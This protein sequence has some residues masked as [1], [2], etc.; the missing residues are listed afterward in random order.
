[1]SHS[2]PH[3]RDPLGLPLG[4]EPGEVPVTALVLAQGHDAV[5][6]R[7]QGQ[8][9]R[10]HPRRVDTVSDTIALRLRPGSPAALL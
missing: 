4:H 6:L 1:M 7:P 8:L 5:A 2:G 9:L 3:Y 10:R